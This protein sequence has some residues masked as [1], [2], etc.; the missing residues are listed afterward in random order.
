MHESKKEKFENCYAIYINYFHSI[1]DTDFTTQ[2][3][4]EVKEHS[5]NNGENFYIYGTH[6]LIWFFCSF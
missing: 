1:L 2:I 6:S 4:Q 3:K 5:R